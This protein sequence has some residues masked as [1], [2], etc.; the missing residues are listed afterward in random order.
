MPPTY[1]RAIVPNEQKTR[2]ILVVD[3]GGSNVKLMISAKG[4]RR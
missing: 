2:K 3:I 4:K 1:L